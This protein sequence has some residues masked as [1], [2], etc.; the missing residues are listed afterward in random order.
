MAAHART[1]CLPEMQ[2]QA[3]GVHKPVAGVSADLR[4]G[5]PAGRAAARHDGLHDSRSHLLVHPRR[6]GRQAVGLPGCARFSHLVSCVAGR[7][8]P[9]PSLGLYPAIKAFYQGDRQGDAGLARK[10][11]AGLTTGGIGSALAN[12]IDLVKIRMQGEAGRVVNGVY[13]VR[14]DAKREPR[15]GGASAD[16][17]RG[18]DAFAVRRHRVACMPGRRRR[19]AT[20]STPFTTLRCTRA[21]AASTKVHC[22]APLGAPTPAAS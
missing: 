19:I 1:T 13:V 12:P 10:V 21:C 11:L 18:D 22:H 17:A 8:P 14:A 3:Q 20:R 15:V 7:T 9:G 6:Y 2:V 16:G 4:R 5:R